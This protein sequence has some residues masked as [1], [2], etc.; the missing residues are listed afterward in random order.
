MREKIILLVSFLIRRLLYLF[1]M[2]YR[3]H[4]DKCL[5]F[6]RWMSA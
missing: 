2:L 3:R 4:T 6:V 1:D 5:K